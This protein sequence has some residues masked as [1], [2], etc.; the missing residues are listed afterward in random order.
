M[1]LIP[2]AEGD[3]RPQAQWPI[4]LLA[5][6]LRLWPSTRARSY[7]RQMAELVPAGIRGGLAGREAA[8]IFVQIASYLEVSFMDGL[9]LA[10]LVT[11]V[12]K[13]FNPLPR[14]PVFKAAA[15]L[16]VSDG[17]LGL[18]GSYVSGLRRRF[19]IDGLLGEPCLATCGFLEGWALCVLS[20]LIVG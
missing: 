7:L 6:L 14:E 5:M 11:D 8:D 13:C 9:P 1:A 12:V 15:K 18:W 10:G 19:R 2:K 20:M 3:P 17:V 16:G 4:I